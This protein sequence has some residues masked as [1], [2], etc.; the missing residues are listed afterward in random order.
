MPPGP[1]HGRNRLLPPPGH[2]APLRDPTSRGPPMAADQKGSARRRS[3]VSRAPGTWGWTRCTPGGPPHGRGRA[4]SF[5]EGN[6]NL[7]D[8][9][10]ASAPVVPPPPAGGG[11][12]SGKGRSRTLSPAGPHGA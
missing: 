11:Q 2:V 1:R 7:G 9:P 5:Y 8:A 10:A 4:V 12:V 6:S 3:I